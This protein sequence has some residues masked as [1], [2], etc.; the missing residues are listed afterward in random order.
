MSLSPTGMNEDFD[1]QAWVDNKNHVML[2]ENSDV[3]LATYEYEGVYT[4][5]WFYPNAKGRQA[6]EL[7]KRMCDV[8]FDEYGAKCLRGITRTDIKA[9]RWAARQV[10]M[11]SHGIMTFADGEDYELFTMIKDE[12]N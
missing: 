12:D 2:V 10:G 11:K 3:G 9:A 6:I 7:A 1:Y 4:V 8:M 5:H